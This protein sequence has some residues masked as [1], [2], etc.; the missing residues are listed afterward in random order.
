VYF[1]SQGTERGLLLAVPAA[2]DLRAPTGR[3]LW[4]SAPRHGGTSP[5][6]LR[7]RDETS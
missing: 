2:V 5:G 1:P 3:G 4:R 7:Q 6:F